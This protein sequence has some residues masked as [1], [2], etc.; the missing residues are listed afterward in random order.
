MLKG[1][2]VVRRSTLSK[3]WQSRSFCYMSRCHSGTPT[4]TAA[5]EAVDVD[6]I[7][8]SKLLPTSPL[9]DA[10]YQHAREKASFRQSKPL[11]KPADT[12]DFQRRLAANPYGIHCL[13]SRIAPCNSHLPN[14][15]MQ[16]TSPQLP[17]PTHIPL[18]H[19]MPSLSLALLISSPRP[20]HSCATLLLNALQTAHPF[21]PW[22]G[23]RIQARSYRSFHQEAIHCATRK[24]PS[25]VFQIVSTQFVIPSGASD[26]AENLE[27]SGRRTRARAF[28]YSEVQGLGPAPS[29][30]T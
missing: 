21:S 12:T 4:R 8:P 5:D 1:N 17:C 13:H 28:Q 26:Q 23:R 2:N 19:S 30:G 6:L 15:L 11:P 20:C 27:E 14:C 16:L 29:I 24:R 22:T 9:L 18:L 3:Q 10:A 25:C 7:A